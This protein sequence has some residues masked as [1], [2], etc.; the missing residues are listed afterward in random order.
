MYIASS[1]Y[2]EPD[3]A[4]DY[5][6]WLQ[7]EETADLFSRLEEETGFE[8]IETYF[9]IYGFGEYNC[10]TW[11]RISDWSDVGNMRESDAGAEWLLQ[12]QQF[13]DESRPFDS[14][15]LRSTSDVKVF[16]LD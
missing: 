10:E 5:K 15:A 11:W 1:Y 14:R 6:D 7:S 3:M 8:Y 13:V 2:L 4:Q 16:D 9:T 12:G